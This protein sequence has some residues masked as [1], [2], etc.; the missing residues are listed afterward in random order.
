LPRRAKLKRG[1]FTERRMRADWRNIKAPVMAKNHRATKTRRHEGIT[2]NRSAS[3]CV[4]RTLVAFVAL[5]DWDLVRRDPHF[6]ELSLKDC[7][8]MTITE[9]H[10]DLAVANLIRRRA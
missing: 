9:T 3:S 2:Q 8:G 5:S 7:L 6:V 4:L 1:L 10:I